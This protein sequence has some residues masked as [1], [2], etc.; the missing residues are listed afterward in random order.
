VPH[1]LRAGADPGVALEQI[2][3]FT[4]ELLEWNRGAS[5][6]IS[7]A[8]EARVVERH[9]VESIEPAHWLKASGLARW[10]DL[11]SG[12]GF[13]AL[14]LVM[15]GVG[16]HWTL[17]ESRRNKT[18]FLRKI[19]QEIQLKSVAVVNE[20]I[21]TLVESGD[22]AGA[23]DGF[24]SR[25]T[26][27]LGPTLDFARHF[28]RIGGEAFLWK[29]SGRDREMADDPSWQDSWRLDGLLGIGPGP[30]VVCRFIREK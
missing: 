13:P 3:R 19:L 25:A 24:T 20:R 8:D 9:V 26:V 14:P 7:G 5:N 21:E 12:G 4:R 6:L 16:E 27:K 17:V 2:K 15:C 22:L 18:L 28:L 10:M 23:F 30:T 1:L 29:G 11:G